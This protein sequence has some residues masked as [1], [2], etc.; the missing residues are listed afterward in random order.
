MAEHAVVVGA[1]IGGLVAALSLHEIGVPVT[2]VETVEEIRPLGVG[3]NL[4]PHAVREL[5]ELGLLDEL[6]AV[7][8]A[9]AELH[10]FSKHGQ[11]IWSEPRGAAAGYRWPQ[12]SVHRGRLQMLLLEAARAR[13]GPD[14][15]RTGHEAVSFE[16]TPEGE[17]RLIARRRRDGRS[18]TFD[19]SM[20]I[21]A[22]GIHSAVRRQLHPG[23]G[24]P[25]WNGSVMWRGTCVADPILDGRSMIWAGHPRQKVVAYPIEDLPDG[26]QVINVIAELKRDA[27]RPDHEQDWNQAGRLGERARP[28]SPTGS[29]TGWTARR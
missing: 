26:R 25:T 21:G 7:A 10:Y 27:S 19:A 4:Q 2:V 18:A 3:I 8:I 29:S 20:L 9:P 24:A 1:G 17:A 13:L 11:P 15:V 14:S 22:D 23:E 12:L 16:T 6:A 28:P 5:D